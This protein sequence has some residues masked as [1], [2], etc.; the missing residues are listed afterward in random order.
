MAT[1]KKV[2]A[3]KK[4]ALI[5]CGKLKNQKKRAACIRKT[6]RKFK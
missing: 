6:R 5:K 2:P 1:A 4:A 3:R